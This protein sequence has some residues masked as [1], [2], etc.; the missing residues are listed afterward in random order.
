MKTRNGFVSNSS[1]AS[2]VIIGYKMDRIFPKIN[3]IEKEA[4][5][6]KYSPQRLS[7]KALNG[8]SLEEVL[9][10]IWYD[11]IYNTDFGIDGVR[12]LSDDGAGYIGILLA[13]VKSE[14]SYLKNSETSLEDTLAKIKLLQETF[15]ILESPKIITGTRSC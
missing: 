15:G 14:D 10:E 11:F 9:E 1:S 5:I 6:R 8:F 4:I 7:K 12:C 3:N 13:D 2:F